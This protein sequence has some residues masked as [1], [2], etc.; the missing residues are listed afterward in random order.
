MDNKT[1]N[2]RFNDDY[3]AFLDE[4]DNMETLP[5]ANII[6]A[7]ITGVGKSTLL[8]AVFGENVSATGI[9][10]PQTQEVKNYQ[11]ERVP[12]RIW[13]TV[14]FELSEDGKRTAETFDNIR[15]IVN[16]KVS[17]RD[18]FDLIHAIWYC[19]NAE[20]KRLQEPEAKFIA[21][22]TRLGVPFIIVMTQCF[23]EDDNNEFEAEIRKILK[24]HDIPDLP[25]V[26]VLAL[27]KNFKHPFTKEIIS[28]PRKGLQEL[29]ELTMEKMPEYL[30]VSFVSAQRID[31][32]VKHKAA[33]EEIVKT[34]DIRKMSN[35]ELLSYNLNDWPI[36]R[37]IDTNRRIKK[38]FKRIADIYNA[39]IINDIALKTIC[40]AS[41][42]DV[43]E[44][45]LRD[46]WTRKKKLNNE[47]INTL[48]KLGIDEDSIDANKTRKVFLVI[49]VDGLRF[50][51][52]LEELWDHSTEKQLHDLNYIV[53][54]MKIIMRANRLL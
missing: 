50:M 22:L 3:K 32:D 8:N 33:I 13:D 30:K 1:N 38:L 46:F 20:A 36:V 34:V 52:A 40:M 53:Q 16:D 10:K 29:V 41:T 51:Y 12:I 31:K 27:E 5:T 19:I 2:E 9:G 4:V 18:P 48:K 39:T 11:S 45:T 28:I 7:G 23:S 21:K 17:S 42:S 35:W 47:V 6:I 43:T 44:G 37:I 25:I 24:E 14:G 15:K 54:N 49:A 26:Q